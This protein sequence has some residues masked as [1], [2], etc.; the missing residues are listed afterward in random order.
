M[1][2]RRINRNKHQYSTFQP[3]EQHIQK[4]WGVKFLLPGGKFFNFCQLGGCFNHEKHSKIPIK[5][6]F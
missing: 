3:N 2:D 6:L 5:S 1:I 4:I